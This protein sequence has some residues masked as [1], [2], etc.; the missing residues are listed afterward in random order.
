MLVCMTS[1]QHDKH[2]S[3]PNGTHVVVTRQANRLAEMPG[4]AWAVIDRIEPG[5]HATVVGVT[6]AG[7]RGLEYT[8]SV[9]ND[10]AVPQGARRFYGISP[11][12]LTI[13]R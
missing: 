12:D 5:T 7:F 11:V 13:V 1:T 10:P 9:G 4:G 6:N 3:I 8:V 2:T